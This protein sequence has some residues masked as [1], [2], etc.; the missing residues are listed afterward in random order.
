MCG[1]SYRRR[2]SWRSSCCAWPRASQDPALLVE[3]H[4]G[5]GADLVLVWE[6]LPL[7]ETHVS[8]AIALYDPQQHRSLAILVWA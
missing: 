1:Q 2:V 8:K 4:Y 5:A 3:A 6:S 7:P